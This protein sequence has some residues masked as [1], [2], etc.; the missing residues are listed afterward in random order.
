MTNDK[1]GVRREESVTRRAESG[2][3]VA[4]GGAAVS[5]S[6]PSESAES[7]A[8]RLNGAIRQA[9]RGMRP[10]ERMTVSEW[11][12]AKRVLSPESAAETGRWRTGRTPYLREIMDAF[13][14]ARV[15][16]IVFVSASQVGKSECINNMIGYIIDQDPGS[17]LFVQPT[18]VDAKE[19]SKLRIAPMIRDCPTL[20][21]KVADPKSRDSANTV[22]QKS[23][24]GGILTMCG[25]QEAHALASKPIR[26]V[27]GDERDRWAVSA[28][29]EGDPWKLARRRQQTFYNAKSVEVSTPTIRGASAIADAFAEGTME[30]YKTACPHCGAYNEINFN[31]IRFEKTESRVAGNKHFTVTSI[32][33]ICP[34]CGGVSDEQTMKRQPC[35]WEAE[36][37][38][39][40]A[41][42]TRSFWLSAFVSPWTSWE[43]IVL[44]YL[45]ALGDAN[46]LQV[47]YNTL[48]GWLW[49]NRGDLADED[50]LLGR[51][52][53]YPAELPD[54]VLLLTM[55]VDT[56]DDRMEYEVVGHGHFGETWGIK[57]GVIMGR[58]D[59]DEVWQAL[60]DAA[61]HTFRFA[62]G[63]GLRVSLIFVDEGGHFTQDVRLR[64][65]ERQGRRFFPI[66]GQGGDGVPYTSPPRQ[67]K[68]VIGGKT[69]GACQVFPLGVDAGKSLIMDNLKVQAPG[70][71]YCHFPRRDD[72]GPAY[73]TGL[74]SERLVYDPKKKH[75]WFWEKIE[76]HERNEPLD[77]RVYALA[78][79]KALQ[80]DYDALA[81]RIRLAAGV[82]APEGAASSE[83]G[84]RRAEMKTARRARPAERYDDW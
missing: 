40:A 35:R 68:I 1:S 14:D 48:F 57:K 13:T 33:Y 45:Y 38:E 64:C 18:T 4:G 62:S 15:R 72:Y 69:L 58:P 83:S 55:G 34:S 21:R 59:T 10:P 12:D 5:V 37:P 79:A 54:G 22:L 78:A 65:R 44:E 76:G 49:E 43:S 25:S 28:G 20:R 71:R 7:R 73:F 80:P 27:F 82:A 60:D 23:Y 36:H 51:R 67:Q 16:H 63:V 46:K 31:D 81:Q 8:R 84:V 6:E 50:E 9:V 39:A 70:P 2:E 26:Y 52:E 66:K 42:G 32:Y 53:E 24:A 29:K 41:S 77:C 17:I 74:M 11:A 75:P 61:G 3:I 47:V 56:Q 30:R 19:Y